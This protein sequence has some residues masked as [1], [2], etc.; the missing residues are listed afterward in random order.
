MDTQ[1]KL[2]NYF[3]KTKELKN[4]LNLKEKN[5]NVNQK[6]AS[7]YKNNLFIKSS[8]NNGNNISMSRNRNESNFNSNNDKFTGRANIIFFN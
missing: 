7:L 6:F 4:E 1:V 3:N 5:I 2:K 8:F